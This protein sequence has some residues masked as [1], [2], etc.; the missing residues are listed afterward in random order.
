VT[1]LL[2][3]PTIG[4]Q[5]RPQTVESI[6]AQQTEIPFDYEIGRHNPFPGDKKKNVVAQYQRAFEMARAGN[7]DALMTVE[8]DM[9]IPPDAIE[10][11]RATDA[12]IVYG[13]YVLRHGTRTL[14][15]WRYENKTNMGMSLSLYPAE[16]Q[17]AWRRGWIKVSGV[18]WGCT[19]I[20]RQVFERFNVRDNPGDAGDI[21]LATDCIRAGIE[22]IAR[23]D[24]PCLHIEPDGNVL[25]PK[26]NGGVVVR[27]L[28]LQTFVAGVG[29]A[30]VPMKKDRYYTVPVESGYELQR[31]GYVRIT[32]MDDSQQE[33]GERDQP[34]ITARE[35]AVDPKAATRG[36]R[37]GGVPKGLP[38]SAVSGSADADL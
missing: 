12:G 26:K 38:K 31:A 23:F 2:F 9:V 28:A 33:I 1:V 13:V 21:S 35:M 19:L 3:T 34:D 22:Q 16:V 5:M 36:K 24:V 14:S 32:N 11:L 27:V 6:Y 29:G 8:D 10:K 18:G 20:R 15:A 37:V 4:E 7:Y 30:S 17:R 25:D